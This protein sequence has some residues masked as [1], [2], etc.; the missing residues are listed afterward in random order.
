MLALPFGGGGNTVAYAQG[1]G[2]ASWPRFLLGE[3]ARRADTFASAIRIVEPVHRAEVDRVLERSGGS[4]V[5]LTE[6][7][8]ERAWLA[9]AREEGLFCEPASAAGDR[10]ASRRLRPRPARASFA[11]SPGTA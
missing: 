8:I 11:S 2:D 1:F 4:V 3:A 10:R 7:Q 6:Q 9:L 5:S